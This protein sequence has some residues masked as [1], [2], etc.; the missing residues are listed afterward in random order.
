MSNEVEEHREYQRA[1]LNARLPGE[2]AVLNATTA[3][4]AVRQQERLRRL[5]AHAKSRSPWHRHRL[6]AIDASTVTVADLARIPVMTKS[7]LMEHWDGIVTDRSL[8]LTGANRHLADLADDEA[9]SHLPGGH[10][11][12]AT[13]GTTGLR[14]VVAWDRD[15]LVDGVLGAMRTFAWLTQRGVLQPEATP[16]RAQFGATSRVHI[17]AVIGRI[18]APSSNIAFFGPDRDIDDI[19]AELNELRPAN[20]AGY[21]SLLHRVAMRALDG[22]LR[23]APSRIGA[24]A[25]PL[26]PETRAALEAAFGKVV[27]NIY[28]ATEAL[29]IATS[30]PAHDG[31]HLNEDIN[32]VEPVDASGAPAAAAERSASILVT[33]LVNLVMPL[34]RYQ[35]TD[36][37]ELREGRCGC[38]H[39]GR[40][41]GDVGGRLDDWFTYGSIDVHPHTFRTVLAGH[42]AVVEYQVRQIPNGAEVS[43]DTAG[44]AVDVAAIRDAVAAKLE[45]AGLRAPRVIVLDGG[46]VQRHGE[47]GKLKRFV[48]L[49]RAVGDTAAGR[50]Q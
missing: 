8:T 24:Q 41:T 27:I 4:M 31:L 36:E 45:H 11:V 49:D 3:A 1:A 37:V 28:G 22:P 48:P 50:L 33:N 5:V 6:G 23:I 12:A 39:P 9:P 38:P 10:V 18:F 2:V 35:I 7:D 16:V 21:P 43:I 19:V 17:S 25:E 14:A 34:I 44:A 29:N 46:P 40:W 42:P 13:G 15:G 30:H 20:V 32:I 26:L 47:T